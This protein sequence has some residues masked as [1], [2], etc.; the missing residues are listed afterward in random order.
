MSNHATVTVTVTPV[1]P[2]AAVDLEPLVAAV[3]LDP[4]P[5]DLLQCVLH[6]DGVAINGDGQVVR[7]IEWDFT[8]AYKVMFP[9]GSG[10]DRPFYKYMAEAISRA[11][12]TPVLAGPVGLT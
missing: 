9:D 10:Q 4:Y 3:P 1:G 5:V 6:S 2:I 12:H 7:T 8:G 11:L